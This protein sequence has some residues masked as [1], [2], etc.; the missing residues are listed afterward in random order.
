MT[1]KAFRYLTEE[2]SG[3]STIVITCKNNGKDTQRSF[4][5]LDC[6]ELGK[7]ADGKEICVIRLR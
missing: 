1:L 5:T 2:M 7:D 3:D 6:I 4:S